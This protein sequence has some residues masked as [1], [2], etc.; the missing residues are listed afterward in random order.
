MGKYSEIVSYFLLGFD[1][2]P[3][4]ERT[5]IS[6][7]GGLRFLA[8]SPDMYGCNMWVIY[9]CTQFRVKA[10]ELP[11]QKKSTKSNLIVDFREKSRMIGWT[12]TNLVNKK[13]LTVPDTNM[14]FSYCVP[15]NFYYKGFM[16]RKCCLR[17]HRRALHRW[18]SGEL[19][20]Q[21][22]PKVHDTSRDLQTTLSCLKIK[23]CALTHCVHRGLS[24]ILP[25]DFRYCIQHEF[26]WEHG[27]HREFLALSSR[28]T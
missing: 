2:R 13:Q 27:I 26:N 6:L 1:S 9:L 5:L 28:K 25:K 7:T 22:F 20:A 17:V 12:L 18:K 8:S 16:P 15:R 21:S 24:F 10:G 11:Q 4:K 14:I 23:I 19:D 3:E